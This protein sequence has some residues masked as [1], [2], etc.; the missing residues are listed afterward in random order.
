VIGKPSS[1]SLTI[2]ADGAVTATLNGW[3]L[4]TSLP[5]A[6][7]MNGRAADNRI[8]LEGRWAPGLRVGGHWTRKQ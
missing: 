2:A 1:V 4:K 6:G 3:N 5:M 7:A 8:D